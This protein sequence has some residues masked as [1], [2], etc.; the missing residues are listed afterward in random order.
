MARAFPQVTLEGF[1]DTYGLARVIRELSTICDV[2]AE[3]IL[4][5]WQDENNAKTWT[6][7]GADL[8]TLANK[9]AARRQ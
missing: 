2:K 9:I 3:H 6:R 7:S 8:A 4:T 1:V 5:N